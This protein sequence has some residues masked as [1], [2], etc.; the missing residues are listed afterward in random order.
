MEKAEDLIRVRHVSNPDVPCCILEPA[1]E[2]N[3]DVRDYQDWERG[4]NGYDDESAEVACWSDECYSSSS[5][6]LMDCMVEYG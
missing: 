6:A 5:E 1:S 3:E 4:M 2:S